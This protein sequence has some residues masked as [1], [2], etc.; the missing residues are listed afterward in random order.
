MRIA[1]YF[2]DELVLYKM[3]EV[4]I[5]ITDDEPDILDLLE[6][7]LEKDG[8]QVHRA[9]NGREAVNKA[10]RLRPG[11]VLLDI[12][13]PEMDGIE[14]CYQLR[15]IPELKDT[16]IIFLTARIEEYVEVAAFE[17][18]GNDFITKPIKPR[19]LQARLKAVVES[20]FARPEHEV[21]KIHDLELDKNAY[22]A[23][24]GKEEISL[25]RLEFDLLYYMAQR[26][27]KVCKRAR[28]LQSVWNNSYIKERTVDVH[29][30]RLRK[31]LG[32]GYIETLKGVGYKFRAE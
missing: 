4:H 15:A 18:G 12:S 27:G 20:Q 24:R 29:I 19:A 25:S 9:S 7:N 10:K 6:Y 11:I 5:L 3:Q 8:Y 13:M 32:E 26:A 30:R 21:I 2:R 28:L 22:V 17:A 16:H 1:C 23:R 31:A 14:T